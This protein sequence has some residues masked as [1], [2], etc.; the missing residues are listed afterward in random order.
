M[1]WW[2]LI[3]QMGLCGLLIIAIFL[4]MVVAFARRFRQNQMSWRPLWLGAIGLLLGILGTVMGIVEAYSKMAE[5]GGAANPRT[6][7]TGIAFSLS[8]TGMGVVCLLAG[9]VMTMLLHGRFKRTS[10]SQHEGQPEPPRDLRS[11]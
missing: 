1:I 11:S 10:A 2:D 7:S 8:A 4:W 9:T 6:L 3:R 5:L